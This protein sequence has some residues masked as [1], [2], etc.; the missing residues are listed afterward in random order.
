MT[1]QTYIAAKGVII[2]EARKHGDELSRKHARELLKIDINKTGKIW[3]FL[4]SHG[5]IKATAEPPPSAISAPD[6]VMS[7]ANGVPN[8]VPINGYENFYC[9]LHLPMSLFRVPSTP[10]ANG[11]V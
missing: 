5:V 3:D 1:P 7:L 6:T 9:R 2:R 11:H 4:V 10:L 8:G